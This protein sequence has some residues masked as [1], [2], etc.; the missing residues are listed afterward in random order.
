MT[1]K[2]NQFISSIKNLPKIDLHCHL[3]GSLRA[4]TILDI[5]L[6]NN[7]DLGIPK[8][9]RIDNYLKVSEDCNSLID[10]LEKFELPL[11]VLQ[12]KDSLER[13]TFEVFEDAYREGIVYLELRFAPSL[14]TKE[15]D[16]VEIIEA[17][18]R[19]MGNAKKTYPIDG[20]IILCCMKHESED[21]A[22]NVIESGKKFIG[23]GVVA[24]DLAGAEDEG[25]S[26][27]FIK[28][29]RLA[30]NYGYKL[31]I[32]AGEAAS[33]K[34]VLEA[35]ELLK[36]DRIGHG[37]RTMDNNDALD[38]IK[39]KNILLE[40]CPSSNVQT[41]NADSIEHHPIKYY[42]DNGFSVSINT[43]NRTVSNTNITNEIELV[44]A[45]LELDYERYKKIYVDT[46]N[47]S[48]A[49][50]NIKKKIIIKNID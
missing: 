40:I 28:S 31:S 32:H 23:N 38:I 26:H 3:D 7:I 1:N 11:K 18:V 47:A 4:N 50:E 5:A 45:L 29:M 39:S 20:N 13:C 27:K 19:G 46:V 15:L 30:K 36:A 8:D 25:F 14:H 21:T 10:Y 33:G 44:S 37:I 22:I 43:D 24:I 6:K 9:D 17:V 48:F 16:L 34:N 35:I 42:V 49:D 2:N 41:K 12:T